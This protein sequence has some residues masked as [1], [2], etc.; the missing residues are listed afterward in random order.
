M[1]KNFLVVCAIGSAAAGMLVWVQSAAPSGQMQI[2]AAMP[3]IEQLHAMARVNDL[4][5]QEIKDLY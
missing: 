2:A 5:V 3:S 1:L 4:P